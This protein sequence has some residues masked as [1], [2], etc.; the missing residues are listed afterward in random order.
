MNAEDYLRSAIGDGTRTF[1]VW[2]RGD[3][4]GA[5]ESDFS[6][7]DTVPVHVHSPTSTS[8]VVTEGSG[9]ETDFTGLVVPDRD[10]SGTV[11]HHVEV[12]DQLRADG[13]RFDVRVKE[14]IPN[15]LDPEYFR[16]GLARANDSA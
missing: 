11:V 16:L 3:S 1:E 10:A 2:R 15:D 4:G 9:Q 5:Y 14:G 6:Q 13:H 12:N 7:V 8:Q